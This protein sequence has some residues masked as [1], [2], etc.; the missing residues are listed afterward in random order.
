MRSV[1]AVNLAMKG[2]QGSVNT[3]VDVMLKQ[4]NKVFAAFAYGLLFLQLSGICFFFLK[5]DT[6]MAA[7]CTAIILTSGYFV[8]KNGYELHFELATKKENSIDDLLK[9]MFSFKVGRKFRQMLSKTENAM[10]LAFPA[11]DD[12]PDVEQSLLAKEN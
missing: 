1:R 2:P 4:R 9:H 11:D 7:I 8:M 10:E 5:Y 6:I 3:S 12:T